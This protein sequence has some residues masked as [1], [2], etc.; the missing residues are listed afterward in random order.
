MANSMKLRSLEPVLR[1]VADTRTVAAPAKVKDTVYDTPE[2]RAFRTV[3]LRRAGYRCEAMDQRGYRCTRASP[4]D[5]LYA[6]HI[7]ELSDGGSLTDSSNGQCLC[8]SHHQSKTQA[9]RAKRYR[10][11]L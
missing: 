9:V 7:V 1:K 11:A 5:R 6:D 10:Q 3:V 8:A 4:H 2:F